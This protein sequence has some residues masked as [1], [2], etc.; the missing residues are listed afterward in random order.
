MTGYKIPHF[1]LKKQ[2]SHL[3]QELLDATDRALREGICLDGEYTKKF[4]LW[5]S[6]K[7]GA[8]YA[9]TLHSCT[10]A[11]EVVAQYLKLECNK[12]EIF[13]PFVE[14]PNITY[15]ATLNA[16]LLAGF[17]VILKDT[18]KNGVINKN[19]VNENYV[20]QVGLYGAPIHKPTSSDIIDGA[21]HWLIN[22][23]DFGI[24]MAISFDPT[25][26]L[27]GPGNGGALV[28]NDYELHQFVVDYKNNG[29]K[30][31][32]TQIG[33]NSRMSEVDCAHLL[34]KTKYIDDWQ[35][36]RKQIR[37]FY[38]DRFKNLPIR[39]LSS[40][41]PV[42]ADQ[43]FVIYYEKRDDLKQFLENKEIEVKIHYEKV[44]SDLPIAN[45]IKHKPDFMSTSFML[46]KGVLSLPIYPELTD[47][48]VE[49]IADKIIKFF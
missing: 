16:F 14:I 8:T 45:R 4:E 9:T 38:I 37:Y 44:L 40:D 48:E 46:S 13:D 18:D 1:G 24:G 20:C 3:K 41:Y 49:Y 7:T 35:W 19:K 47:G 5:L 32:H 21:Q 2:Y 25:K 11:L 22:S 17:N 39:C 28:T 29:K 15:P 43:K 27:S 34:V 42:H 30:L 26:N 10:Q 36:R 23:Q 6:L 33:S 31:Y 12:N